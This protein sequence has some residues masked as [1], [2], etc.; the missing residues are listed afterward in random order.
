MYTKSYSITLKYLWEKDLSL[1]LL[2]K[3]DS[4][5]AIFLNHEKFNLIFLQ[6]TTRPT[7]YHKLYDDN[8]LSPDCLQKLTYYLCHLYARYDICLCFTL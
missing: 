3:I 5:F 8:D 4:S 1:K 7:C 2:L 6:G